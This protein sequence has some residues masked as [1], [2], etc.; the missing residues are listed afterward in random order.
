MGGTC[1]E[2]VASV[3]TIPTVGSKRCSAE[4]RLR[5]RRFSAAVKAAAVSTV[6]CCGT[7]SSLTAFSALSRAV[8]AP[9][10]MAAPSGSD[11]V[12]FVDP[13]KTAVP[14]EAQNFRHLEYVHKRERGWKGKT[15][16]KWF[17]QHPCPPTITLLDRAIPGKVE[18][19]TPREKRMRRHLAEGMDVEDSEFNHVIQVFARRATKEMEW[20]SAQRREFLR[21]AR[22]WAFE[23]ILQKRQLSRTT[24]QVILDGCAATGTIGGAKYWFRYMQQNQSWPVGRRE[25]NNMIH[26]FGKAARPHEAA[27]WLTWMDKANVTADAKSY[28]GMVEAWE[29]LGNRHYMLTTLLELRAREAAGTLAE[30]EKPS[31]HALPYYAAAKSYMVVGDLARTI[32]ILKVAKE[33]GLPLTSEAHIIRLRAHLKVPK[34][35]RSHDQIRNALIDAI[36]ARQEDEPIMELKVFQ[37]TRAALGDE[38]MAEILEQLDV[39]HADLIAPLPDTQ[40]VQK[41]RKAQIQWAV[42]QDTQGGRLP[43]LMAEDMDFKYLRREMKARAGPKMG[44]IRTGIR[45]A[46]PTKDKDGIPE[47]MR[48]TQPIK[49]AMGK[50]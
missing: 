40:T 26:T 11:L 33:K 8:R 31:D 36:L 41:W 14:K 48:L 21:R 9:G 18:K 16:P 49:Y 10:S 5:R 27:K 1:S 7:G 50:L 29:Q 24:V 12:K 22:R 28:A 2:E 20:M 42:L 3:S 44:L 19:A 13:G 35:R 39:T 34:Q 38:N 15:L 17:A 43:C 6:L 25:Y 45:E 30:P 37:W 32:S 46:I 47:W 4:P 23:A